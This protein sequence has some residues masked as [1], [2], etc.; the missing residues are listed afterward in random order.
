MLSMASGSGKISRVYAWFSGILIPAVS[1]DKPPFLSLQ[2]ANGPSLEFLEL[3]G[4]SHPSTHMVSL[5]VTG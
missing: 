5:H 1:S 2:N 3:I 4:A